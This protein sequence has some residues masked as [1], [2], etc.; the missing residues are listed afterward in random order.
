MIK[1]IIFDLGGVILTHSSTLM[2][3]IIAKMFSI[4]LNQSKHLY[5][6]YK[7]GLRLGK[8]SSKKFINNIKKETGSKSPA[9]KLMNIWETEYR[10]VADINNNVLNLIDDLNKK[11][12]TY[13][14]TDTIDVHDKYNLT[15]GI[16]LHFKRTFKSFEEKVKKPDKK[17]YLNVLH[18]IDSKTG[19]C[20]FI[21]NLEENVKV[22]QQIGIKGIVYKNV[23]QL[24]K[25]LHKFGV[26]I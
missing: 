13:L 5:L 17:S 23:L 7:D 3:E 11:Y 8:I 6:K 16:Y 4:P 21:D 25:D 9:H 2:E 15:R 22:A 1:N 12:N 20:V 18:K 14:L 24:K 10:K 19:E 26:K